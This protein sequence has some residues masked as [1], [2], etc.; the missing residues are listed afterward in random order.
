[1]ICENSNNFHQF[2][3]NVLTKIQ[4]LIYSFHETMICTKN[5]GPKIDQH[6]IQARLSL[7]H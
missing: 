4:L 7:D 3:Q 6:W 1:M 5:T 2:N